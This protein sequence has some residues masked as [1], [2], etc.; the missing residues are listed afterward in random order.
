MVSS[1]I[2]RRPSASDSGPQNSSESPSVSV[3]TVNVQP[4]ASGDTSNA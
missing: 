3:V 4:A 2:Q 1:M